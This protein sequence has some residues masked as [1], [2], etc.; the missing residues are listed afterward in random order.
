MKQSTKQFLGFAAA[1]ALAI[2]AVTGVFAAGWQG[3]GMGP[4]M[5]G[6]HRMMGGPGGVS[7][8]GHASVEATNERLAEVKSTLGITA[9]QESAWNAYEQAVINQSAL[10]NAH[11][12]TM[13]GGGMAPAGDQRVAMHQQ[14]SQMVQQRA[15][16]TQN[17][18]GVLTPAQRA[19]ADNL[20]GRRHGQRWAM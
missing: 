5:G 10:M 17:L 11:R 9:A 1:S 20:I 13:M 12:E 2:G 7:G 15:Q 16:A 19:K 3:M 8:M 6:H 18:Y 4:G 14:G